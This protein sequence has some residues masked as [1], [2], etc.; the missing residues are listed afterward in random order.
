MFRLTAA[1]T[2]SGD[3]FSMLSA[4]RN[5]YRGI[6]VLLLAGMPLKDEETRAKADG[7]RGFELDLLRA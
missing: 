7:A 2:A 1:M 4:L 3:G 5:A 6:R